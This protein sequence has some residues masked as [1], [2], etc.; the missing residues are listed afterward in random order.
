MGS[1]SHSHASGHSHAHG[2]SHASLALDS[3]S[4]SES[5]SEADL[6]S[7]SE[8]GDFDFAQ[9]DD[10]NFENMLSQI[11]AKL[12]EEEKEHSLLLA[13]VAEYLASLEHSD[14]DAMESYLVQLE[15]ETPY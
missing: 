4:E 2:H 1:H 6:E 15:S 3:A 9:V 5:D 11:E 13:Q 8:G 14:I 12:D 7:D 10:I